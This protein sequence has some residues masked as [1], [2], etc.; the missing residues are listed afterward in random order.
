MVG[1]TIFESS[2]RIKGGVYRRGKESQITFNPD[3]FLLLPS[4]ERNGFSP[5]KQRKTNFFADYVTPSRL[6][7]AENGALGFS[8]VAVC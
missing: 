6:V 4:E 8:S 3:E 1:K 2:I 5:T 7:I